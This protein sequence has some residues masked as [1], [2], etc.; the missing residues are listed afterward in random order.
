MEPEGSSP[1]SQA[2][3]TYPYPEPTQSS[4]HIPKRM[5][6]FIFL[7]RDTSSRNTPPPPGDS[8]VGVVYLR[9]VLS[10]EEA[11]RPCECF[12]T[13]FF[14]QRVVSTS[15]NPQAGGPPL[16]GC[17]RLLIQFIRSYPP[18]RR[19]FLHPQRLTWLADRKSASHVGFQSVQWV[20]KLSGVCIYRTAQSF[21]TIFEYGEERRP[22]EYKRNR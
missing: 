3:A 22:V 9:I 21:K 11:S 8:S 16:V 17:P 20:R 7:K 6:L 12:T 10:P 1:H 14:L 15:P 18:Y 19:P 4:P 5:S 13:G 2:P